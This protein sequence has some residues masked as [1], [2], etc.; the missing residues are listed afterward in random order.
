[1]GVGQIKQ[2]YKNDD[3]SKTTNG[4]LP[5]PPEG[6]TPP[7]DDT[8]SELPAN[9]A[10]Q[11]DNVASKLPSDTAIQND[12]APTPSSDS[13]I[14]REHTASDPPADTAIQDNKASSNAPL[15]G[16]SN[17]TVKNLQ[18]GTDEIN[19][20]IAKLTVKTGAVQNIQDA[21]QEGSDAFDEFPPEW[22]ED[23]KGG[24]K[25][26]DCPESLW[27][28][29]T[30]IGKLREGNLY[31]AVLL[32]R[33]L[34]HGRSNPLA[35]GRARRY[36]N[37]AKGINSSVLDTVS[38]ANKVFASTVG[39][40]STLDRKGKY[41][42]VLQG[43]ALVS[44]FISIMT[45]SR[46]IYRKVK[47][48]ITTFKTT[49]ITDKFFAGIALCGDLATWLSKACSI[50]KTIVN[51]FGG[52]N[53]PALKEVTKW[54]TLAL[55]MGTQL[56]G[57]T[58]A[59]RAIHKGRQ[60][61]KNL[62]QKENNLWDTHVQMLLNKYGV[63]EEPLEEGAQEESKKSSSEKE[64]ENK[65][66]AGKETPENEETKEADTPAEASKEWSSYGR[67]KA[68]EQLLQSG[69]LSEDEENKLIEYLAVTRRK[70][71]VIA[72]LITTSSGLVA[73]VTGLCSSLFSSAVYGVSYDKKIASKLPGI[74]T[75]GMG[76][77]TNAVAIG[78]IAMKTFVNVK[79]NHGD[80][81]TDLISE[82]LLSKLNALGIEQYGLKGVE[83]DLDLE[84]KKYG[85]KGVEEDLD[86]ESKAGS[87]KDMS[88]TK[89]TA[90]KVKNMYDSTADLFQSMDVPYDRLLRAHNMDTF[91][92]ILA[93]GV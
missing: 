79:S 32:A 39:I 92:E 50:A 34:E 68:V 59:S 29:K 25:P 7:V 65:E 57:I 81:R 73:S 24:D 23:K 75:A 91:K 11:N 82:R 88:G 27:K 3:T 13:S 35:M 41:K 90:D 37:K 85:L 53:K 87:G 63:S 70:D 17:E 2:F 64:D 54:L 12:K 77:V 14:Q 4:P 71:K 49:T 42:P 76:T 10:I 80:S 72:S 21:G 31:K 93:A 9:T 78:N 15:P 43:A 26:Q 36:F 83:A 45:T 46:D 44:N 66:N 38:D 55:N 69:K 33:E 30:E 58:N 18:P 51:Y 67:Q 8:D 6:T 89:D 52:V 62:E 28:L 19:L 16:V 20:D 86:L 56:A 48:F 74:G 1:M 5:A 61:C 47:T 40:A 22:D 60:K 84:S